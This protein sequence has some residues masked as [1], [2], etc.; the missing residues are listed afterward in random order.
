MNLVIMLKF[1]EIQYTQS[2]ACRILFVICGTSLHLGGE[3]ILERRL[4][5][6]GISEYLSGGNKALEA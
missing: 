1:L 4:M 6:G 5:R 2:S 3:A